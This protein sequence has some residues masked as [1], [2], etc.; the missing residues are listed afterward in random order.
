MQRLAYT[1][2]PPPFPVQHQQQLSIH[3]YQNCMSLC[4]RVVVTAGPPLSL[5]FPLPLSLLFPPPSFPFPAFSLPFPSLI[6]PLPL[7]MQHLTSLSFPDPHHSPCAEGE[8]G[9]EGSNASATK[10]TLGR[11]HQLGKGGGEREAGDALGGDGLAAQQ[12]LNKPVQ[13][14]KLGQRAGSSRKHGSDDGVLNPAAAIR[15]I[16]A[17]LHGSAALA[18]LAPATLPGW[19]QDCVFKA[20]NYNET[21]TRANDEDDDGDSFAS[22]DMDVF[23][24]ST[25]LA[26]ASQAGSDDDVSFCSEDFDNVDVPGPAELEPKLAG[27]T[28][29]A[30]D[31][32]A[33]PDATKRGKLGA[34]N[35]A[36]SEARYIKQAGEAKKDS[37]KALGR[38]D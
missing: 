10:A 1:A 7:P 20:G 2:E 37:K 6:P 18:G 29:R 34:T 25:A 15:G 11:R 24:E 27:Q 3:V 33:A 8:G 14:G 13:E 38:I 35:G 26:P 30:R 12:V 9:G 22:E 5:T 16:G 17:C 23:R 28:K 19:D 36:P 4:R 21:K 31:D 32:A